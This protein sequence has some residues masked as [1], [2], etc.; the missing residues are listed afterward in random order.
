MKPRRCYYG[1]R[2]CELGVS[3]SDRTACG[4]RVV[5]VGH[6]YRDVDI[7]WPGRTVSVSSDR[8]S[9]SWTGLLLVNLPS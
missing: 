7:E 8:L 3:V 9:R 5:R 6:A 1:C 4:G 2:A